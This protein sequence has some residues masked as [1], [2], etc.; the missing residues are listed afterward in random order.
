MLCAVPAGR[1]VHAYHIPQVPQTRPLRVGRDGRRRRARLGLAHGRHGAQ[2][3][4]AA[5]LLRVRWRH[6]VRGSRVHVGL[7]R[8]HHRVLETCHLISVHLLN[9]GAVHAMMLRVGQLV[10]HEG[11]RTVRPPVHVRITV[12][13]LP[14]RHRVVDGIGSWRQQSPGQRILVFLEQGL[15]LPAWTVFIIRMLL[16]VHSA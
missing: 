6:A 8:G 12:H 16:H 5:G 4:G 14:H 1:Q 7:R 11:V 2:S 15:G 13:P 10:L 9:L 3:H